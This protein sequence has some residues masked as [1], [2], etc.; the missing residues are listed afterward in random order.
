MVSPAGRFAVRQ[1]RSSSDAE[2][3]LATF[4]G[5][6]HRARSGEGTNHP[7]M[8]PTDH[9]QRRWSSRLESPPL[10]QSWQKSGGSSEERS[11]GK[12][13]VSTCKSRGAPYHYKKQK[14][15]ISKRQK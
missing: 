10:R 1:R 5:S 13:C 12:E 11:V 14:S 9:P 4:R 3:A 7:R 6:F 2:T 15:E 8:Q